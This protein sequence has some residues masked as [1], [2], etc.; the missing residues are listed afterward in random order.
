MYTFNFCQMV[1]VVPYFEEYDTLLPPTNMVP[2]F[3]VDRDQAKRLPLLGQ[4]I[5]KLRKWLSVLRDSR[6]P[7]LICGNAIYGSPD[8][9]DWPLVY[10]FMK[11]ILGRECTSREKEMMKEFLPNICMLVSRNV[12][13]RKFFEEP[14]ISFD[15]D[16]GENIMPEDGDEELDKY[17]KKWGGRLRH[18]KIMPDE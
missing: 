16:P 4:A 17:L 9:R 15:L 14:I 6:L 2:A 5:W 8:F 12:Q 10:D 11:E 3:F 13:N 18:G 7:K 1:Y